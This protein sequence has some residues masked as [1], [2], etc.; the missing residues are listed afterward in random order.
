MNTHLVAFFSLTPTARACRLALVY[1]LMGGLAAPALAQVAPGQTAAPGPLAEE[2]ATAAEVPELPAVVITTK[3]ANRVSKGA[4]G[5]PMEVKETPQSISTIDQEDIS[6][7]GFTGSNDALWLGTGI[8]V[9]QYETNRATYNSRGFDVQLTQ[10][11]GLGMSNSW[12]TVVGQQDSF[13]FEKIEL[14]RG[15]NGLLTGV[16][17]ASGTINYVRKRPSNKDGGEVQ[18]TTGSYGQVRGALDYNKVLTEDGRWAGRL[19]VTKEDA[20]SYLRA[21][22]TDRSAFY[23]VVDG[24]IGDSGVLTL[25][26]SHQD[27]QQTS[28]MWG[29]LTLNRVDG[30]QA[31]FDVSSSTSQDWTYWNT[32]TTSA[33]VEYTHALSP[34]WEAKVTFNKSRTDEDTRLLYAY[35]SGGLNL[36]NTGL[37][38]W[39]YSSTT[40]TDNELLDVNVNGLFEAFGREHSLIAGASHST[41]AYDTAVF[42]PDPA[43]MFLALP[44][45]PY[46]GNVYAEPSW[47]ALTPSTSGEQKLTRLYGATRLSLTGDLKAILGINAVNLEREGGSV[48]GTGVTVTSYPSTRKNSPYL[49]FTYDFSPNVLGYASYSDIFQ[50]QDQADIN[51]KFLD[52]M[53]GRNQEIGV[54]AEWLD[55]KLLTTFAV[56]GAQQEGLAT[57]AGLTESGQYFYTPQD[58]KSRGFEAEASGKIGTDAKLSL[59]LTHLK[60]TGADGESTFEWVPRTT[61]NL[62]YDTRLSALPQLKLGIAGRWQSEVS[63]TEGVQQDGYFTANAFASYALNNKATLRLNVYNLFNKKY[64]SSL[65]YGAIYGAPVSGA[66][67]LEYKL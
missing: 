28:P 20:D 9:E 51:G 18:L 31:E 16:G 48:Y 25:G 33:F 36:D 46:G 58:V 43:D 12:G 66:L 24:Q 67:T 54:K 15:A 50:Y 62:R 39:P 41:Q 55:R 64:L 30:S 63:N 40:E 19:V 13:L 47:G 57:Y 6:D 37:Y 4:T 8:N 1:A 26:L 38:G 44:A 5:L 45:F 49:G 27:S 3:R 59:G 56:F 22:N 14:I 53:K 32:Q 17:N 29:N 21:V 52:P 7:F 35:T 34:L 61:V 23:G 60:L 2:A 42:N 10:I 65:Q 11:D